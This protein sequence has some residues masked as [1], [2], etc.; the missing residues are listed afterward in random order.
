M[1][2]KWHTQS[3]NLLKT[4]QFSALLRDIIENNRPCEEALKY[5]QTHQFR[6]NTPVS[7]YENEGDKYLQPS[8]L[9]D[10]ALWAPSTEAEKKIYRTVV[11]ELLRLQADPNAVCQLISGSRVTDECVL[12]TA[13]SNLNK[14]LVFILLE[15]CE[16]RKLIIYS[17]AKIFD[18][19]I[20]RY[21]IYAYLCNS[22]EDQTFARDICREIVIKLKNSGFCPSYKTLKKYRDE[23]ISIEVS[24][25]GL[26]HSISLNDFLLELH[27][28]EEI[29]RENLQL[30]IV[31]QKQEKDIAS[32][33]QQLEKLREQLTNKNEEVE[34]IRNQLVATEATL[35]SYQERSEAEKETIENSLQL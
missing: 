9:H 10:L 13:I 6:A 1:N 14:D 20:Y 30:K 35:K 24:D 34:M 2:K 11:D 31:N 26:T 17:G 27:S 12:E 3:E 21:G 5:L 23:T 4:H 25:Q 16:Q 7:D 33:Q 22:G 32:L 19:A 15:M 18:S 29:E 8:L 28:G